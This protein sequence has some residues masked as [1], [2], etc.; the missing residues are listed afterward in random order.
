MVV[1]S[2]PRPPHYRSVGSRMGDHFW[3]GIPPRYVTSHPGQLSLLSSVEREM[4]TGQCAVMLCGSEWRQDGSFNSWINVWVS[5]KTVIPLTRAVLSAVETSFIIQYYTN[6]HVYLFIQQNATE[7]S[8]IRPCHVWM[9]QSP[10]SWLAETLIHQQYPCQRATV[11]Y[12]PRRLIDVLLGCSTLP[13]QRTCWGTPSNSMPALA[14][15][16]PITLHKS[17]YLCICPLLMSEREGRNAPSLSSPS[18]DEEKTRLVS[19]FARFK[20]MTRLCFSA[21]ALFLSWQKRHP[22]H[23]NPWVSK[24]IYT[25]RIKNKKSLVRCSLANQKCL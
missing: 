18:V 22:A 20:S 8:A 25:Q 21:L 19:D 15:N 12:H 17:I 2:I 3:V 24:S 9:S 7:H 6:L 10:Q 4:S 16:V 23:R 5:G 14:A 11:D 13:H 1:S